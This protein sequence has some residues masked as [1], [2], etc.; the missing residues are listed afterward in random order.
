LQRAYNQDVVQISPFI[1][2]AMIRTKIVTAIEM[3]RRAL[4]LVYVQFEINDKS[5]LLFVA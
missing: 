4:E 1:K 2:N 5:C 3:H